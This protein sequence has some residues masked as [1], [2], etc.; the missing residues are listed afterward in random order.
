MKFVIIILGFLS[1]HFSWAEKVDYS[2]CAKGIYVD[3]DNII[4][5]NGQTKLNKKVW[6]LIKKEE[7][8][9]VFSYLGED[10]KKI[11]I[12]KDKKKRIKEIK[13]EFKSY[14]RGGK[15][16]PALTHSKFFSFQNNICIPQRVISTIGL[17]SRQKHYDIG[18]CK[19][20]KR[21]LRK[22]KKALQQCSKLSLD[23]QKRIKDEYKIDSLALGLQ[24]GFYTELKSRTYK[25]HIKQ[26]T[27]LSISMLMNSCEFHGGLSAL[28]ALEEKQALSSQ[29]GKQRKSVQ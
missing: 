14:R 1:F 2:H 23:F 12:L 28:E 29:K 7:G 10:K 4:E 20:L 17:L 5:P 9:E 13:Y 18:V 22:N 3:S 25:N 6:P 8:K 27:P 26:G 16:I 15:L 19:E 11:V 24:E 21:F